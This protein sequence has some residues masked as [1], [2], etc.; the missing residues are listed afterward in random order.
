MAA[1]LTSERAAV[2]DPLLGDAV[3]IG[4]ACLSPEE[5]LTL[6]R[7]E[8]GTLLY[9]TLRDKPIAVNPGILR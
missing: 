5:G 4:R 1:S 2:Q 9:P 8:S 3:E 7:G 6:R